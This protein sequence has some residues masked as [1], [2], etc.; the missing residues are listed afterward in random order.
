MSSLLIFF[1]ILFAML[2]PIYIVGTPKC[3]IRRWFRKPIPWNNK[4]K[5]IINYEFLEA[6]YEYSSNSPRDLK[7]VLKT[8]MHVNNIANWYLLESKTKLVD[9]AFYKI[10]D[11]VEYDEKSSE[12]LNIYYSTSFIYDSLRVPKSWGYSVSPKSDEDRN[13]IELL[14]RDINRENVKDGILM[15]NPSESHDTNRIEVSAK[16]LL[17]FC[18]FLREDEIKNRYKVKLQEKEDRLRKIEEEIVE[19]ER[20]KYLRGAIDSLDIDSSSI[21]VKNLPRHVVDDIER[22]DNILKELKE[23]DKKNTIFNEFDK[24]FLDNNR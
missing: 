22:L 14:A 24:V 16:S 3:M 15:F 23:E 10:F 13:A 1:M 4:T 6:T 20:E 8:S 19:E 18:L 9:S 21:D 7:V 12:E 5:N 11:Y 17:G 2:V